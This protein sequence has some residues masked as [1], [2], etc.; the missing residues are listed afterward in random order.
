MEEKLIITPGDPGW[1][2]PRAHEIATP[3]K[4]PDSVLE[5]AFSEVVQNAQST[6]NN[7][8]STESEADSMGSV[9]MV[10]PTEDSTMEQASVHQVP[11][12]PVQPNI[13]YKYHNPARQKLFDIAAPQPIQA[14]LL[15]NLP[16]S[17]EK[18]CYTK[19]RKGML[20]T[21][22][23]FTLFPGVGNRYTFAEGSRGGYCVRQEQIKML[24]PNPEVKTND[25]VDGQGV[26]VREVGAPSVSESQG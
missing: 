5:A 21:I 7:T 26:E 24:L 17:W 16:R 14:E 23:G 4:L 18:V 20:I 13:S 10:P 6:L 12:P 11:P 3:S 8:G 19:F 15:E 25:A 1:D 9:S 22:T 2:Q